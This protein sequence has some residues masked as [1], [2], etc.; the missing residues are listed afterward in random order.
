MPRA[1]PVEARR[2]ETIKKEIETQFSKLQDAF[3]SKRL[4][5]ERAISEL[6]GPM[7]VQF[8]RTQRASDRWNE[9]NLFLEAKVIGEGNQAVRDLLLKECTPYPTTLIG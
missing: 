1:C 6:L 7:Y 8:D 4:W 2:T 9:K 5:K 3:R